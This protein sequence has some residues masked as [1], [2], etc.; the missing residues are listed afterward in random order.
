[1]L[2]PLIDHGLNPSAAPSFQ[3]ETESE[4]LHF[5]VTAEEILFE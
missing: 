3:S 4:K 5:K 2:Q 1:M